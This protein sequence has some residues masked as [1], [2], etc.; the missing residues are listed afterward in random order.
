MQNCILCF[1][2]LYYTTERES[3]YRLVDEYVAKRKDCVHSPTQ[4]TKN[5]LNLRFMFDVFIEGDTKYF[6]H[7]RT[8]L[9]VSNN[10]I[11]IDNVTLSHESEQILRYIIEIW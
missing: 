3:L 9:T 10:C 6:L 11:G 7:G 5:K 8:T 1:K 2:K 4:S